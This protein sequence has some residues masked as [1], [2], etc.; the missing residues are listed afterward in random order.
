MLN[1]TIHEAGCLI[2]I[3]EKERLGGGRIGGDLRPLHLANFIA[4]PLAP[5]GLYKRSK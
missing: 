4:S 3:V 5:H 1:D 2:V